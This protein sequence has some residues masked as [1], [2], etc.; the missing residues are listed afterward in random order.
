MAPISKLFTK[1][2][3]LASA[4]YVLAAPKS[5]TDTHAFDL[6]DLG[7]PS[8]KRADS[9]FTGYLGAFFLGDQPDVYFYLSNG[10]DAVSFAALNGGK[11]VLVPTEGTGGVRDPA[12]V[13]GGGTE[14]GKKWYIVGT[15]LD[16]SKVGAPGWLGMTA[17]ADR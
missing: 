9:A 12:I 11:P 2:L 10:N 14:A 6:R 8:A 1:A 16:I 3:L 4:C 17:N 5:D 7:L 15:D 13:Q